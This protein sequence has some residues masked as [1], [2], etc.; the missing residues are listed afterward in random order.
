MREIK[1]RAWYP[2]PSQ[3]NKGKMLSHNRIEIKHTKK[4]GIPIMQIWLGGIRGEDNNIFTFCQNAILM[5]YTGLKDK[6]DVEIYE[7]DMVKLI[8]FIKNDDFEYD[9]FIVPVVFDEGCFQAKGSGLLAHCIIPNKLE[10]IGNIYEN[11][12]LLK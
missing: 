11:K 4:K 1:F 7:G 10:V 8:S 9:E 5:Q 12:E 6:N 2:F 3:K